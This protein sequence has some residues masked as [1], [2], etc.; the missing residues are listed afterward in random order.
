MNGKIKAHR[1]RLG[2]SQQELADAIGMNRVTVS[3]VEVGHKPSLK[4]IK[5]TL[6]YFRKHDPSI[7]FED[8]F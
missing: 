4:F 3:N 7:R 2:I 8:L 1:T 6:A 5:N